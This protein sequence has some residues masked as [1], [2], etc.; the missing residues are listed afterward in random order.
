MDRGLKRTLSESSTGSEDA[1][2]PRVGF[3][4][5]KKQPDFAF[6]PP[7]FQRRESQASTVSSASATSVSEDDS[8]LDG[9]QLSQVMS[10]RIV[11]SLSFL[12]TM[13]LQTKLKQ[14]SD[15]WNTKVSVVVAK[16]KVIILIE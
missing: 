10:Y 1:D 9:Q 12:E 16:R 15:F 8:E 7:T 11:I 13:F 4:I 2:T 14:N 3:K 5:P 6:S